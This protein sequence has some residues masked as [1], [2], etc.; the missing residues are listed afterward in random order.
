M[1]NKITYVAA[2][3]ILLTAIMDIAAQQSNLA[4]AGLFSFSTLVIIQLS[5]IAFIDFLLWLGAMGG[6]YLQRKKE[7][8]SKL[9]IMECVIA[10]PLIAYMLLIILNIIFAVVVNHSYLDI[11]VAAIIASFIITPLI[12]AAV[13]LIF[14]VIVE[15]INYFIT[16]IMDKQV[17][18][19]YRLYTISIILF[20]VIQLT[21]FLWSLFLTILTLIITHL[22]LT[23]PL[24][25]MNLVIVSAVFSS[26]CVLEWI[27]SM[28]GLY[29]QR[30]RETTDNLRILLWMMVPPSVAYIVLLAFAFTSSVVYFTL[31]TIPFVLT[32]ITLSIIIYSITYFIEKVLEK[33][34]KNRYI[35]RT[36]SMLMPAVV[37]LA[38][39]LIF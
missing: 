20:G 9:K 30:G 19:Q 27:G 13:L 34:I 28:V 15:A 21:L 7:K 18:S 3:V 12:L 37:A 32:L 36:L 26:F 23:T 31:A 5:V 24:T 8:P 33:R 2:A 29:L 39:F 4:G 25:R 16:R 14:V 1:R 10:T 17:R 35:R 22:G 38:P 11:D 6:L